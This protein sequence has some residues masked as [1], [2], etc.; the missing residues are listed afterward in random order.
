[1]GC[2]R[3]GVK[4]GLAV[5]EGEPDSRRVQVGILQ[6]IEIVLPVF[7]MMGIGAGVR[8]GGILTEEADQSL[9][10][11]VVNVL[12]PCLVFD[13]VVGNRSL[14]SW[15][16]IAATPGFAVGSVLVGYGLAMVTGWLVGMRDVVERR[17]FAYSVSINN[18]GYLPVPLVLALFGKEVLGV[19]FLYFMGMELCLW[20]LASLLRHEDGPL[21]L[22]RLVSMPL[23]ALVVGLMVNFSGGENWIPGMVKQLIHSLAACAVPMSLILVGGTVADLLMKEKPEW[24]WKAVLVASVLRLGVLPALMLGTAWLVVSSQDLR[25]VVV[26][27]AA[28]PSGIFLILL[29]KHYGGSVPTAISVSLG[30]SAVGLVTVPLWL[31]AGLWM[32]F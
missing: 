30:T 27:Q 3:G 32:F 29:T 7:L 17:T 8:K 26:A 23:V 18:Y 11:L 19:L 5:K 4:S 24:R 16:I 21:P 9:M 20:V 13:S 31:L 25:A 1:M 28:M 22:R 6:V 14:G 10:R 12:V 15:W 2:G